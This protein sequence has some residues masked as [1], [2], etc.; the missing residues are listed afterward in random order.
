MTEKKWRRG[1]DIG[2][3]LFEAAWR[4]ASPRY[5]FCTEVLYSTVRK[6]ERLILCV[7]MYDALLR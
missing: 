5:L 6:R 1:R 2:S 3:Y 4:E 7:L